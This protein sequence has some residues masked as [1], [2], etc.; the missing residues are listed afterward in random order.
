LGTK[1]GRV[2]H[3]LYWQALRWLAVEHV[4]VSEEANRV[5]AGGLIVGSFDGAPLRLQYEVT[6]DANWRTTGVRVD[7]LDAGGHIELARP[8]DVDIEATPFTNTLPIRRLGLEVGQREEITAVFVTVRPALSF[9]PIRQRYSRLEEHRYLYESL[10]SEFKS[11]LLVDL[12]GFVVE[13]PGV[14]SRV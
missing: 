11:E 1:L 14:W 6:C 13:Y 12:D 9:R 3:D 2:E 4:H 10:E 8:G 5:R 7:D